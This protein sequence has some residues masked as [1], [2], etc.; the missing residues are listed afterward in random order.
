MEK[1]GDPARGRDFQDG[2]AGSLQVVHVI[3]I[4]DNDVAWLERCGVWNG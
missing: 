2:C 4:G 1:Y 3:E